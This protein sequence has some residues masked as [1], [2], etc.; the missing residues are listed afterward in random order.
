MLLTAYFEA[1]T[2]EEDVALVLL[3][4]GHH[5]TLVVAYDFVSVIKNFAFEA[6]GKKLEELPHILVLPPHLMQ[7]ALPSLYKAATAFVLPTRGEG[8]GRPHVEAMA[9][10]RPNIATA[11]VALQNP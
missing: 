2:V 11:G 3:T 1:C 8:W 9:M 5:S 4:N 7:D 6:V 10:E